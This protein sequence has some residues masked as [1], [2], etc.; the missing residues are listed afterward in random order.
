ME[1]ADGNSTA[2]VAYIIIAKNRHGKLGRV[3]LGFNGSILKFE[4]LT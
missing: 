1:D 2:G 3:K 4:P